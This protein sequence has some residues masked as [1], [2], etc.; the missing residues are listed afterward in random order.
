MQQRGLL[1]LHGA[2]IAFQNHCVAVCG[3]SGI[4]KSTLAAAFHQSGFDVLGDDI[5]CINKSGRVLPGLL[6]IHLLPESIKNLR[7]D[8]TALSGKNFKTNKSNLCYS[9]K[10]EIKDKK[11]RSIYVIEETN[12]NKLSFSNIKSLSKFKFILKNIY[13]PEFIE[14]QG[15]NERYFNYCSKLADRI[16]LYLIK[17]PKKG[18]LLE[19]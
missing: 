2:T 3:K 17:R 4:G 1:P 16:N 9:L 5:C 12:Q 13:R 14:G 19:K 18:F 6:N 15:L 7:V 11:I 10:K 8:P